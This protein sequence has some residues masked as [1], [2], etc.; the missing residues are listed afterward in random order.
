M[1][2]RTLSQLRR[3]LFKILDEDSS[4]RIM[5]MKKG[6]PIAVLLSISD[7]NSIQ[8]GLR[9]GQELM[10]EVVEPPKLKKPDEGK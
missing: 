10:K 1:K 7:Y 6:Q 2:Y 5:V 4:E 8:A 9:L 3:D